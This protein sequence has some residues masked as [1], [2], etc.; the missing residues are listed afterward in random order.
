MYCAL[1][2]E[3]AWAHLPHRSCCCCG[4]ALQEAA[5]LYEAL[6]CR[7]GGAAA[8]GSP[9]AAIACI[10]GWYQSRGPGRCHSHGGQQV[11]TAEA[12]HLANLRR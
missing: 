2:D 8:S 10:G 4:M 11:P 5:G 3:S 9:P 1:C 7:P 6:R 12:P